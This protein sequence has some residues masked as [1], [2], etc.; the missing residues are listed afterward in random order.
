MKENRKI[1]MPEAVAVL[2]SR[3]AAWREGRTKRGPMPKELW[4]EAAT[5]G[6]EF[7]IYPVAR[8][9]NLHYGRLKSLVM[10]KRPSRSKETEGEVGFMELRAVKVQGTSESLVA[11]GTAFVTEVELIKPDGMILRARQSGPERADL[12]GML[13][14]CCGRGR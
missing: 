6:R 3:I 1:A 11:E 2:A 13:S 4:A 7:G 9:L 8:D 5:L 12:A 10:G 14:A